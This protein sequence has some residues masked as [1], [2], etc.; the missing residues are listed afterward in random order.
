[1]FLRGLKLRRLF[2]RVARFGLYNVLGL[3]IAVGCISLL[4]S[5]GVLKGLVGPI[6]ANSNL[7]D[8]ETDKA[9][10]D[11]EEV[12]GVGFVESDAPGG[13]YF[14]VRVG[15][16]IGSDRPGATEADKTRHDITLTSLRNARPIE[17]IAERQSVPFPVVRLTPRE[18]APLKEA[19]DAFLPV[20]ETFSP[21]Q[22]LSGID[23][24]GSSN[25]FEEATSQDGLIT[26]RIYR[27]NLASVVSPDAD[28][29]RM[30][31]RYD[32][33]APDTVGLCNR[34]DMGSLWSPVITPSDVMVI[35]AYK[36]DSYAFVTTEGVV[37][38]TGSGGFS[39]LR[40]RRSYSLVLVRTLNTWRVQRAVADTLGRF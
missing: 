15:T 35:H 12:G 9:I 33:H 32:S 37:T 10:Q 18:A 7:V 5:Q 23:D 34:C 36:E 20:W 38:Y 30:V 28:I 31:N 17:L 1:M 25:S 26:E 40:F 3:L 11:S 27:R 21:G 2:G 39:G 24:Q 6:F 29:T 16:T 4:S 19:V 13:Q 22:Y 8:N 14:D